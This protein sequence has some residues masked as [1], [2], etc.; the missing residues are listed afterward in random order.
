MSSIVIF[1]LVILLPLVFAYGINGKVD[2]AWLTRII[3]FSAIFLL[4]LLVLVNDYLP[5]T[6]GGD[7]QIYYLHSRFRF[8]SLDSL[9]QAFRY[10]HEQPGYPI[11]LSLVNAAA[12]ESLLAR[13]ALNLSL[14][15][16]TALC[17]Y[18]IGYLID[19]QRM[20]RL[21][22]LATLLATPLWYYFFFLL[23]DMAITAIFSFFI[24]GCFEFFLFRRGIVIIIASSILISLFRLPLVVVNVAIVSIFALL[25]GQYG[26]AV[27]YTL[28]ALIAILLVAYAADADI[29]DRMG[30]SPTRAFTTEAL[31]TNI[32]QYMLLQERHSIP[33]LTLLYFIMETSALKE[34]G[35]FSIESLRG[36]TVMPWIFLGLPLFFFATYH[37]LRKHQYFSNDYLRRILCVVAV[38]LIYLVVSIIVNDTTRWRIPAFPAM[39]AIAAIGWDHL[40]YKRGAYL[41]AAVF[42]GTVSFAIYYM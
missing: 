1:I 15:L 27:K 20:A 7:D 35:E 19:G 28:S 29:L 17:W 5:F 4:F 26:R 25:L 33:K 22:C 3:V 39:T 21:F 32:E 41:L 9:L 12:G 8:Q 2:R 11:L 31:R 40:G 24:L 14:F 23:K 38:L 6:F 16:L 18:R 36:W 37:L 10:S 13:K 30:I 42:I 34:L